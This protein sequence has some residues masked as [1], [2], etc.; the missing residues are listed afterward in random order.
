MNFMINVAKTL[1]PKGLKVPK[2]HDTEFPMNYMIRFIDLNL[3][4]IP[5]T[6][7]IRIIQ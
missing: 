2:R 4:D 5:T 3:K 7:K 6:P 1:E